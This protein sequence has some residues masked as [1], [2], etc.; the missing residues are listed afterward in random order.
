ME[1][2]C[3]KNSRCI[4]SHAIGIIAL[5]KDNTSATDSTSYTELAVYQ[6]QT[7]CALGKIGCYE[8]VFPVTIQF[9]DQSTLT[10]KF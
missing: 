1:K 4:F 8:L 10:A 6:L 7:D 9:P 5:H 2:D 3:F